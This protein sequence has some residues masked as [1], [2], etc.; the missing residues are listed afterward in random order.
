MVVI[1][2]WLFL[3]SEVPLYPAPHPL[4]INLELL[5]PNPPPP[6]DGVPVARAPLDRA[7]SA[8]PDAGAGTLNSKHET[9]DPK[10]Q[11]RDPKFRTPNPKPQ[12][13]MKTGLI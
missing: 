4:I 1:G 10:P 9:R 3:M 7:L 5:P 2:G 6:T 13:H 8:A 11:T 12:S